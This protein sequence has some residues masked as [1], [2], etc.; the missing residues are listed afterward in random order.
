M[1]QVF[2]EIF[3]EPVYTIAVVAHGGQAAIVGNPPVD[4]PEAPPDSF[5][6]LCLSTGIQA[7]FVDL[8]SLPADHWLQDEMSARPLGH[9]DMRSRW[10]RH[11]DAFL[12]LDEMSASTRE[13]EVPVRWQRR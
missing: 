3:D 9:G 12:F 13:S 2:S 11:F 5:E 10:P 7:L 8:K 1:G 4:L 6:A